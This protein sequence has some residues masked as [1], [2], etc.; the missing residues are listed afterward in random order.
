MAK[1]AKTSQTI[2][3]DNSV[4]EPISKNIVKKSPIEEEVPNSDAAV[5]KEIDKFD[6][7]DIPVE[8]TH[9]N[10]ISNV[11]NYDHISNDSFAQTLDNNHTNTI[12][13]NIVKII[14]IEDE[15]PKS[16]AVVEK[17]IDKFDSLDIPVE[18]TH[19]NEISNVLNYEHISNDSF[20]QPLDNDHSINVTE[21]R[22]ETS[23]PL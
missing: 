16:D 6:P 23:I 2:E 19:D 12:T 3:D 21:E 8:S 15:V 14:S 22:E 7:L 18:S 20:A 10:E 5:E 13:N 11:L 1:R 4:Y 9:D 17:E